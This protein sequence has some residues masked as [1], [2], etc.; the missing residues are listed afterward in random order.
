LIGERKL[1]EAEFNIGKELLE[2]IEKAEGILE[3][4]IKMKDTIKEKEFKASLTTFIGNCTQNVISFK[5]EDK[6]IFIEIMDK[7]IQEE[8]KLI[9]SF[10]KEF[11]KL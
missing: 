11:E 8:N 9:S 6:K 4:L 10:K 2:N 1:T 5:Q 7:L 3:T